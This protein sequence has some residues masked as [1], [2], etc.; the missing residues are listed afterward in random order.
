M[1]SWADFTPAQKTPVVEAAER[2]PCFRDSL[3]ELARSVK[4]FYVP[5]PGAP[6]VR[7]E[8]LF[9]QAG[10]KEDGWHL[11]TEG[12]LYLDRSD[13]A[14]QFVSAVRSSGLLAGTSARRQLPKDQ[15]YFFDLQS[16]DRTF[17][18]QLRSSKGLIGFSVPYEADPFL[19]ALTKR[20]LDTPK[21]L[22]TPQLT[23]RQSRFRVGRG[24]RW[25]DCRDEVRTKLAR[26]D[27][28][29]I[30]VVP[31][32]SLADIWIDIQRMPVGNPED[33][34]K[35]VFLAGSSTHD[36]SLPGCT[37][38]PLL[39]FDLLTDIEEWLEGASLFKS[40]RF[41]WQPLSNAY[42]EHTAAAIHEKVLPED[43]R[44]L[45][46]IYELLEDISRIFALDT[47]EEFQT[48]VAGL[49]AP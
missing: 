25:E 9:S 30:Q 32:D 24:R 39:E 38:L 44:F 43:Q 29:I 27:N 28:Q 16:Y 12:A 49:L 5:S 26:Q 11:L 40:D 3:D 42:V 20:L 10:Y 13:E 19:D 14:K 7:L 8:A 33:S 45:Y 48:E 17:R 47:L 23:R 34:Y 35:F 6:R 37:S 2:C 21:F 36:C 18:N 41:G 15:A 4:G 22:D 31:E 46:R 1:A